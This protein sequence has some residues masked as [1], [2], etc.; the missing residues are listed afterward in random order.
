MKELFCDF[1][2]IGSWFC[3]WFLWRRLSGGQFPPAKG[4]KSQSAAWYWDRPWIER[5]SGSIWA[6][7]V[8][9][10]IISQKFLTLWLFNTSCCTCHECCEWALGLCPYKAQNVASKNYDAGK[11][12]SL[13]VLK[14]PKFPKG[15][16]P[17][18]P[19]V[20][21]VFG[22]DI[23]GA[24]RQYYTYSQLCPTKEKIPRRPWPG[25]NIC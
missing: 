22:T 23:I 4:T 25:A 7:P 8:Q 14:F 18:I 10:L 11:I 13:H 1:L 16:W 21:G 20:S 2:N 3:L 6:S 17:L 24:V 15:A 12:E 5:C 9:L 19:L